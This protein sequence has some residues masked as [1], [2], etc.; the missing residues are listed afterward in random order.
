[1]TVKLLSNTAPDQEFYNNNNQAGEKAIQK[2]V[3]LNQNLKA[4][5]AD[6]KRHIEKLEAQKKKDAEELAK[7]QKE[8]MDLNDAL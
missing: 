3:E 4:C 8:I 5:I 7:K 2:G 6:L 1:M